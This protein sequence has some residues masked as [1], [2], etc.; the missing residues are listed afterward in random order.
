MLALIGLVIADALLAFFL[1]YQSYLSV[2]LLATQGPGA[3]W[4]YMTNTDQ[5]MGGTS[6]AR[7]PDQQRE[8][9]RFDFKL[10]NAGQYPFASAGMI[11]RDAKGRW[12][13]PTGPGL[14]RFRSLPSAR[15]PIR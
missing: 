2:P 13:R 8:Q 7:I 4:Q 12:P 6:N 11:L 5:T 14:A 9:L 15:R 10:T 3:G 1:I